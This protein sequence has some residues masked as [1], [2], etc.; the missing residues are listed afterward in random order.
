MVNNTNPAVN[1][2]HT[3]G[4]NQLHMNDTQGNTDYV[5]NTVC[6]HHGVSRHFFDKIR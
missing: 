4:G 5:V 3:K 2:I 6:T 1:Q